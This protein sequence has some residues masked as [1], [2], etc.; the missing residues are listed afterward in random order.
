MLGCEGATDLSV[1]SGTGLQQVSERAS[2]G[3]LFYS[4]F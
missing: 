3:M 2:E 4:I 1:G